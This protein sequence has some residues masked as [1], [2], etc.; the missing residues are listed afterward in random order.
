MFRRLGS[1]ERIVDRETDAAMGCSPAAS[2]K[3]GE[4]PRMEKCRVQFDSLRQFFS[5][6]MLE[7]AVEVDLGVFGGV[8]RGLRLQL[9][10]KRS[11]SLRLKIF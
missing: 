9:C 4:A 11:D 6:A 1:C 8:F 2:E 7:L 10:H 5:R 3:H